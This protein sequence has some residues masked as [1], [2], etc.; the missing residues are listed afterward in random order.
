MHIRKYVQILPGKILCATLSFKLMLALI[1]WLLKT[2]R[3]NSSILERE[4]K[5]NLKLVL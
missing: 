4:K 1:R 2:P 5:N 3:T